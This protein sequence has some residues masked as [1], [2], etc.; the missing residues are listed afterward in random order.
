MAVEYKEGM[1]VRIVGP[2]HGLPKPWADGYM[3]AKGKIERRRM[4]YS[5]PQVQLYDGRVFLVREECME[6][7][8]RKGRL[9][10]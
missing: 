8:N 3:G 2:I 1:E 6:P 9:W 5:S 10:R 4:G 7:W